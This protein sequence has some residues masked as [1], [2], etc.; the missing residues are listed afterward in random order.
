MTYY[1]LGADD[2]AQFG[3]RFSPSWRGQFGGFRADLSLDH[4]AVFGG[5]PFSVTLDRLEPKSVVDASATWSGDKSSLTLRGRY[6]FRLPEAVSPVRM[7]RLE[8]TRTLPL[9]GFSTVNR[10]TAEVA[11]LL[12]PADEAI[13][14]FVG[15]ETGFVLPSDLELGFKA[16]YDL[17]PD[18]AG[19]ELLEVYASYPLTFSG[20]TLRPFLGLNAAPLLTGEPLPTVTGYGL[21]VAIKSCCGTLVASYRLHDETVRTAFDVRLSPE[22][23]GTGE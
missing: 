21:S 4:Q 16:R 13:E 18:E 2:A 11:G 15:A 19:L 14:A 10:F 9:G 7:V 20:V 6:A 17:L 5:S 12:G 8:T 3:V 1:P 23:E 22:P